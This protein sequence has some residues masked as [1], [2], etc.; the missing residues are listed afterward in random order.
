MNDEIETSRLIGLSKTKKKLQSLEI[1][2]RRKH[3][4]CDFGEPQF[5][6]QKFKFEFLT[7]RERESRD[8]R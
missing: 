1:F 5:Q 7:Q 6:T 4:Q 3:T 8:E 2:I